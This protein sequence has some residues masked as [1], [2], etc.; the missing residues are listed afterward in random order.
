[1]FGSLQKSSEIMI[2]NIR[3][4]LE[5]LQQSSEVLGTHSE[6]MFMR[7]KSLHLTSN[8]KLFNLDTTC[9]WIPIWSL[10][11]AT[12]K[13]PQNQSKLRILFKI[14]LN[15]KVTWIK[16]AVKAMYIYQWK[17]YFFAIVRGTPCLIQLVKRLEFKKW[18]IYRYVCFYLLFWIYMLL[19]R[20]NF[21]PF[22][23][24]PMKILDISEQMALNHY[25]IGLSTLPNLRDS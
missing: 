21:N 5:N 17:Y 19:S 4:L 16:E 20:S 9:D 12:N 11:D 22:I 1:M 18:R 6:V 8:L 15:V 10:D 7:R 24:I 13:C 2:V 14:W 3:K 25:F 23:L